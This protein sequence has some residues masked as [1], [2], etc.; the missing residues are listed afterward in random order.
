MHKRR[1]IIHKNAL[2]LLNLGFCCIPRLRRRRLPG[3]GSRSASD[4]FAVCVFKGSSAKK[5]N[6]ASCSPVFLKK[7]MEAPEFKVCCDPFASAVRLQAYCCQINPSGAGG[8]SFYT[9]DRFGETIIKRSILQQQ[10]VS[11]I[12]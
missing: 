12:V 6:V 7:T 4:C 9:D 5:T 11:G 2:V 10:V 8:T 3:R 1:D